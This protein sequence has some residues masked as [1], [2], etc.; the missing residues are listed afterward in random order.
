MTKKNTKKYHFQIISYFWQKLKKHHQSKQ[1]IKKF[2]AACLVSAYSKPKIS[3]FPHGGH[4]D[5]KFT[6]V[7]KTSEQE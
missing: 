3:Q 4:F 6:I 5:G 7:P 2:V 1:Q